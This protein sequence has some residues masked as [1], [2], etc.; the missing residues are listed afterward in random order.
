MMEKVAT[1]MPQL[2]KMLPKLDSI[3]GSFKYGIGR[4]RHT[5]HPA[6]C[7]EPDRQPG[8]NQRA[9]ANIDE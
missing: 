5:C 3:L 4:P 1:M 9:T 2:E 7:A 6:Q 8:R